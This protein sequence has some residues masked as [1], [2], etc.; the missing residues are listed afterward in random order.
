LTIKGGT[1]EAPTTVAGTINGT[2][3]TVISGN[4]QNNGT[5]ASAVE[6]ATSGKLSTNADKVTGA[7]NNG[8]NLDLTGGDI[9]N[10]I[11]GSGTTTISGT[12]TN[13]TGKNI[14]NAITVASTGN[15][16]TA[17]DKIGGTVENNGTTNGLKLTG[18]QLSQNV[19]GSGKTVIAGTDVSVKY[20][21][22]IAQDIEI[23][24]R[25]KLVNTNVSSIG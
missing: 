2:G 15:L 23:T 10:A 13:S 5:I 18:G 17:A 14:G 6:I 25:N 21:N 8:G 4:A 12:V 24:S 16:T 22:S 7:I 9:Q 3:T 1:A 19:T 20:G 11:S